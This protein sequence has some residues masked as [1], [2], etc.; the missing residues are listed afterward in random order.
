MLECG[1][2]ALLPTVPFFQLFLSVKITR[3]RSHVT[4]VAHVIFTI[5]KARNQHGFDTQLTV[6]DKKIG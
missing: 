5:L 4:F 6:K 2:P 1:D 3:L